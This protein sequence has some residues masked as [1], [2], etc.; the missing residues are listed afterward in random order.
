MTAQ[1]VAHALLMVVWWRGKPDAVITRIGAAQYASEQ[2]QRLM[3]DSGIVCNMSR[4]GDVWDN[5]AAESVFSSLKTE[6]TER[7]I[8]RIGN[9]ARADVFEYIERFYNTIRR[10]STIGYPSPV[11][12]RARWD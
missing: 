10:H 7:K 5:A 12:S 2:F 4:S 6:P 8:Y 1:L 3:A 11:S 9:E